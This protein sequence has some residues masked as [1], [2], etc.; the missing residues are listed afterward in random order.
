MEGVFFMPWVGNKYSEHGFEGVRIL[1]LG[2]SHWCTASSASDDF[3][4]G[5]DS[6]T[7]CSLTNDASERFINYKKGKG[8]CERWMPTWTKFINVFFGEAVSSD[9]VSDFLGINSFL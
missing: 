5:C 2:E 9:C 3:C 4:E 7:T 6:Y 8:E 1:V